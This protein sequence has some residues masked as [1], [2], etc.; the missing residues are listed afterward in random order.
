MKSIFILISGLVFSINV[1]A[2]S[3]VNEAAQVFD[4]NKDFISLIN[5]QPSF[6][7]D[8]VDDEGYVEK[9]HIIPLRFLPQPFQDFANGV[10]HELVD[11]A[12]RT[13]V[14][15]RWWCKSPGP[16]DPLSSGPTQWSADGIRTVLTHLKQLSGIAG[17]R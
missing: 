13:I 5:S 17:S 3:Y 11:Y 9:N 12:S 6:T 16:H 1:Y 4:P 7:I 8:H 10:S 14:V 2:K 15:L